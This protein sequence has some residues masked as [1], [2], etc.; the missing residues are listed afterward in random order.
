MSDGGGEG[1]KNAYPLARVLNVPNRFLVYL[2]SNFTI[3]ANHN[4]VLYT[5]YRYG[6]YVQ[7]PIHQASSDPVFTVQGGHL[8]GVGD[9]E[10]SFFLFSPRKIAQDEKGRSS[11]KLPLRWPV[12]RQWRGASANGDGWNCMNVIK[13]MYC[14]H[15]KNFKN[16]N[17][18][19]WHRATKPLHIPG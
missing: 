19:E 3:L 2:K 9:G 15:C 16:K 7:V 6:T 17:R 14:M 18:K 1:W 8:L 11:K 13:W 4:I 10:G 5:R 12:M